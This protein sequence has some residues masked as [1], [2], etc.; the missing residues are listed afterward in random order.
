M[1]DL[2]MD[3]QGFVETVHLVVLTGAVEDTLAILEDPPG[4]S[5]APKLQA[6]SQWYRALPPG[7]RES[8]RYA[9]H[10]A[11]HGAV[12]G[13]MAVLDG[14][15][16]VDRAPHGRLVLTWRAADGS[17]TLLNPEGTE[18]HDILQGLE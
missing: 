13:M 6:A 4:R 18:L 2:V 16:A 11:A 15:R 9:V 5:P 10:D 8:V 17:E 7:D 3:S 12:F 14:V 1:H